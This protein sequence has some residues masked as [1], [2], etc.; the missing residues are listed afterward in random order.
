MLGIAQDAQGPV[1]VRDLVREHDIR[2][3][4]LIDRDSILARKLG[5]GIVPSGF[6]VERGAVRYAH[7]DDFDIGDPRV[8]RNLIAFLEGEPVYDPRPSRPVDRPALELFA[9]GVDSYSAG[10]LDGA[11]RTWRRALELDPDNFLIRSQIW[12]LEHPEHFYPVVDRAWQKQQLI[13]E[14]YDQPLP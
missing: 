14:G 8:R 1:R 12:A 9:S 3:P 2:F 5:F 11:V 4:V 6:F 10:D 7:T 13:V